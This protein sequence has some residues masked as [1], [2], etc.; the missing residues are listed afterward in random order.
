MLLLL[1]KIIKDLEGHLPYAIRLEHNTSGH[2][3]EQT[4][5]S[6]RNRGRVDFPGEPFSL[7]VAVE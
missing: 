3:N 4:L 7:K 5:L 1:F 2:L 6:E